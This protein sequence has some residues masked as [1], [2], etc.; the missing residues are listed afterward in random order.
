MLVWAERRGEGKTPFFEGEIGSKSEKEVICV[1]IPSAVKLYK[2]YREGEYHPF[3]E[4]E[5]RKENKN[6]RRPTFLKHNSP[7]DVNHNNHK[8]QTF[9]ASF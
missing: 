3:C 6:R 5:C 4:A 7:T 8:I 2:E 9:G 1:Q